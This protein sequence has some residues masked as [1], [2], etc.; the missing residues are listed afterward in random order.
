M[1]DTFFIKSIYSVLSAQMSHV[2]KVLISNKEM[3]G[4]VDVYQ[5]DITYLK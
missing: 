4:F 2:A 1:H 5:M 3:R